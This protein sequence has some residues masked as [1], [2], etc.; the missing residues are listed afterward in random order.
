M[1]EGIKGLGIFTDIL[2]ITKKSLKKER[3]YKFIGKELHQQT[4]E[5]WEVVPFEYHTIDEM[6]PGILKQ[7]KKIANKKVNFQ[8]ERDTESTDIVSDF[9]YQV[10][11]GFLP[12]RKTK[13]VNFDTIV[14]SRFTNNFLK[15][16]YKS[17]QAN[18]YFA[19][20]PDNLLETEEEEQNDILQFMAFYNKVK[21]KNKLL[22]LCELFRYYQIKHSETN[23][24]VDVRKFIPKATLSLFEMNRFFGKTFTNYS[25]CYIALGNPS[26]EVYNGLK[27]RLFLK[28]REDVTITQSNS[29]FCI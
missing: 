8:N 25:Q 10:A 27:K 15:D 13:G 24:L 11:E 18:T 23:A 7:L 16:Y 1:S 2:C 29:N 12:L 5:G 4:K 6:T 17:K 19:E 14:Y 20:L 26:K 21:K 9:L 22:L 28:L 3:K